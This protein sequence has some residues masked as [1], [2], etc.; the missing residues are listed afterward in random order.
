MK[1][2]IAKKINIFKILIVETWKTDKVM[3]SRIILGLILILISSCLSLSLPWCLK[4]IVDSFNNP[5][6]PVSLTWLLLSYGIIWTMAQATLNI[7]NIVVYRPFERGINKFTMSV[8]SKLLKLP[9]SYYSNTSTGSIMSA[10][11]RAQAAI[12]D[13]L[14]DALFVIL[15]VILEIAVTG[16]LLGYFYGFK[17]G[18][19]LIAIFV[20]YFILTW[21]SVEWVSKAQKVAMGTL[22]L[23]SE[24][25]TD[26]LLNIEGIFYQQAEKPALDE[27]RKRVQDREDAHTRLLIRLDVVSLGQKLVVGVGLIFMTALVGRGVINRQLVIGDFILFNGYLLQFILPLNML[28]HLFRHLLQSLSR[29]EDIVELVEKNLEIVDVPDAKEIKA[30]SAGIKFESVVFNYPNK[31]EAIL[32]NISFEVPVGKSSAL[33]GHNGSGKT[34]ITKL[35]Y[36]LYEVSSGNI[37]IDGNSID[38][39]KLT[40]LRDL[41]GVVPQDVFLLNNT[42]YS[43]LLFGDHS[44]SDEDFKKITKAIGLDTWVNKL[45]ENY[46]TEIGERGI[47][48]SGGERQKI[49]IARALL[50]HPKLLILDE[51]TSALDTTSTHQVLTHLNNEYKDVTKLIITHDW[52]ICLDVDNVIYIDKGQLVAAGSHHDLM[53]ICTRYQVAWENQNKKNPLVVLPKLENE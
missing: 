11:E 30:I 45:P 43:N 42:I 39:I 21:L 33:V 17:F 31:E 19:S 26:V 27:C 10:I 46:N 7:R 1:G 20:I 40:S 28:G 44:I 35:L 2:A 29:M 41:I 48:L 14:F 15:P 23:I 38:K 18:I 4:F 52:R 24:Y 12:P 6:L 3:Q 34:T 49:G 36:R 25:I 13:I 32:K 5:S 16:G 37:V 53:K 8:F 51:A 47:R 22:K 9:V 50:R